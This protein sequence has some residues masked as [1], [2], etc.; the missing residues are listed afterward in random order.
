MSSATTALEILLA[1]IPDHDGGGVPNLDNVGSLHKLPAP[2][3]HE[4]D[5]TSKK[6]QYIA[7]AVNISA[8]MSPDFKPVGKWAI[9]DAGAGGGGGSSSS[10]LSFKQGEG[11]NPTVNVTSPTTSD[12]THNLSIS[13]LDDISTAP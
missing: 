9:T 12:V 2:H 6:W 8:G 10:D 1:S 4:W 5:I 13:T 11:I 3:N 7:P